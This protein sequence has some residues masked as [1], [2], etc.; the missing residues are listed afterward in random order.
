MGDDKIKL[1]CNLGNAMNRNTA[2][3]HDTAINRGATD[4]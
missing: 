1:H 3:N 4:E 2:I